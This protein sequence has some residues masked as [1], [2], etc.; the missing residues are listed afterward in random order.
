MKKNPLNTIIHING[1]CNTI[2]MSGP[3]KKEPFLAKLFHFFAGKLLK[4]K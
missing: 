2:N 3:A 1:D 4:M